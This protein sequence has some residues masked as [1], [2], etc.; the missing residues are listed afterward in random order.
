MEFFGSN[1]SRYRLTLEELLED[2]GVTLQAERLEL[3]YPE[4]VVGSR[5]EAHS[6]VLRVFRLQI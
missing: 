4:L 5:G 1:A 2:P 6:T 3:H